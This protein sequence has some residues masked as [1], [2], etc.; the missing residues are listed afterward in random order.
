MKP[1][2]AGAGLRVITI[3]VVE[4]KTTELI[5]LI[6]VTV[7]ILIIIII[8]SSLLLIKINAQRRL[9]GQ[10]RGSASIG[11]AAEEGLGQPIITR[12]MTIIS[13]A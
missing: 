3:I 13:E 9:D 7:I 2:W 8:I 1:G 5:V 6:I 12:R 10:A 4:I 11:L